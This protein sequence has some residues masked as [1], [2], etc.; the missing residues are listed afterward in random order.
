MAVIYLVRAVH[1]LL[2]G[3]N[4]IYREVVTESAFVFLAYKGA[5]RISL[6]STLVFLQIQRIEDFGCFKSPIV[7]VLLQKIMR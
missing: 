7:A 2:E 1:I 5:K 3:E 6:K 4:G